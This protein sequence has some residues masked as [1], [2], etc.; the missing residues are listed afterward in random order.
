MGKKTRANI[1]A[2]LTLSGLL[3]TFFWTWSSVFSLVSLWLSQKIGLKGTDTGIIF[4]VISLT[5]F[6]AQPLYGFIQDRLGL[7]KNLLW[8]LG[9]CY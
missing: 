2:Y 3:F 5:A 8:F 9:G 1:H 6:C 4:S 7:R